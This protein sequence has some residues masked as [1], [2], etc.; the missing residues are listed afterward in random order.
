VWQLD[1]TIKTNGEGAFNVQE[2][3]DGRRMAGAQWLILAVSFL[4]LVTDGFHTAVMAFLAPALSAE[5]SISKSALGP[6]L[7]A[8]LIGL[9]VGTMVAGPLADR[10]GR[11]RI[12]I[13]SVLLCANFDACACGIIVS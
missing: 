13:A 11:K 4:V 9:A 7:A 5:L 12:L 6:V 3:M 2:F 10:Y 8:S 1:S